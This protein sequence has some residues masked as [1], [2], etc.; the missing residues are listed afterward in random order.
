MGGAVSVGPPF[1]EM[2]WRDSP[3]SEV[4]FDDVK[5]GVEHL[6]AARRRAAGRSDY[7]GEPR[8]RA[9]GVPSM[10]GESSSAATTRASLRPR[11]QAVRP[12]ESAKFQAVQLKIT[13][14]FLS[15]AP[16]RTSCSASR[17]CSR[18]GVKTCRHQRVQGDE[19]AARRRCLAD[20]HP[21]IHG[22]YGYMEES[23]SRSSR[24]S[25]SSS[26]RSRHDD[27][28]C[29]PRRCQLIWSTG[30]SSAPVRRCQR[31]RR[32]VSDR[33]LQLVPVTGECMAWP[34]V[35]ARSARSRVVEPGTGVQSARAW[36]VSMLWMHCMVT[37]TDCADSSIPRWHGRCGASPMA[38]PPPC[39]HRRLLRV[40]DGPIVAGGAIVVDYE[41]DRL[42]GCRGST[43][44]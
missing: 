35:R 14:L 39:P 9:L 33:G 8:Q 36:F 29:S 34:S 24:A 6:L 44:A 5:L 15:S 4:F 16:S 18:T 28:T 11:A 10:R 25:A 19:R 12:R 37:F 2:A 43:N 21:E 3:T 27:I 31:V 13:D 20:R 17:G 40:G 1:K 42:N 23:G 26:S 32:A 7:Q 22:G 41:F 38:R 30:L